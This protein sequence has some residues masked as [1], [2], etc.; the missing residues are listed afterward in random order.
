MANIAIQMKFGNST[1]EWETGLEY[2]FQV[3]EAN[4]KVHPKDVQEI[5]A[6][7]VEKRLY[8][9]YGEAIPLETI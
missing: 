9:V 1:L 3:G 4:T 7:A 5:V 2:Y 8:E 6:E